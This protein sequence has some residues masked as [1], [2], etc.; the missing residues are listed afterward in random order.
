[1][2]EGRVGGMCRLSKRDWARVRVLG[3][4]GGRLRVARSYAGRILRV[5]AK[6]AMCMREIAI[7]GWLLRCCASPV[8]DGGVVCRSGEGGKHAGS[9]RRE[10]NLHAGSASCWR[11][12]VDGWRGV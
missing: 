12:D 7:W 5:R 11:S 2:P 10:E 9:S 4:Y 8:P 1:M 6:R 3:G